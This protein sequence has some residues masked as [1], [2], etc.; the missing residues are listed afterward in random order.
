MSFDFEGN[1]M[2]AE[3]VF[4]DVVELSSGHAR[5]ELIRRLCPDDACV[6]EVQSLLQAHEQAGGFLMDPFVRLSPLGALNNPDA[7]CDR[8]PDRSGTKLGRYDIV[9]RLGAGGMGEVYL[10]RDTQ[11]QR[12]VGLKILSHVHTKNS[13]WL[14]RFIREAKVA[15]SVNHPNILTVH[16]IGQSAELQFIVTEYVEGITLRDRL[17]GEPLSLAEILEIAIQTAGALDAAHS[18]GIVHRDLKPENIMIRRDGLV[19][20]LD[21]GLARQLDPP[22]YPPNSRKPADDGNARHHDSISLPGSIMGTIHYMSPEQVRGLPVDTRSDLFSAGVVIYEMLTGCQPFRGATASDV[23]VSILEREPSPFVS[24]ESAVPA[25]LRRI[26]SRLLQKD[27]EQRFQTAGDFCAELRK[28]TKHSNPVSDSGCRT[29][30]TVPRTKSAFEWADASANSGGGRD[31]REDREIPE[32]RYTCSGSVNIAY[33]VFGDGDLDLVFVMGWVSHL[34]WFWKEPLFARFLR[35]L[36]TFARVI[37]FDKR[38]TGLSDRVEVDQLPTLEQRMD[39][40]RAVMDAVDSQRAVLC[41]V[42]EGGPM[43]VLFAATYP[44]KT[45]AVTMIGSYAR[46]LWAE[47]YPWGVREEDRSH[48]LEEIRRHWGGPVG[49]EDR[50][51]SLAFDPGFREWWATYL[52]MGASPGAALA[53][54]QMNAQIDIRQ[55]LPMIQVPTLVIHRTN[56][57]CLKI[58]EGRHL[59]EHIPGARF[60]ELPGADHLPFVG[61][62]DAVLAAM[63][64]FLAAME[65]T[66]GSRRVLA[67]VLAVKPLQFL[68]GNSS[69]PNRPEQIRVYRSHAIREVELF[70][71]AN[72]SFDGDNFV[73]VFDGPTRAIRAAM[74]INDSAARLGLKL[75]AGLHIGECDVRGNSVRGPAVD[76]ADAISEIAL[77]HEIVVSSTI[78]DLVAGSGIQFGEHP[79]GEFRTHSGVSKLYSVV[80]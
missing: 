4:R 48:F 34:E 64:D 69:L 53:L 49:I 70:R 60:V 24:P 21:F 31:E 9:R 63:E 16:E 8:A 51:P 36:G 2:N 54:T 15:S 32:V 65:H 52:R 58:E 23:L 33:Q 28:V 19:K 43:C 18:A 55:I 29:P 7:R 50:A 5:Q 66:P 20:V 56:D 37:L 75:R 11:L 26:I 30:D 47:D 41:G 3:E 17:G 38:G 62:Q 57:R 80:R 22:D 76:F 35:R 40:V 12:D 42:S 45:I 27:R 10:A 44:Q 78:K 13:A 72:A 46:R 61:D 67:T 71:G 59:A 1:R 68:S 73:A 77:A 6:R 39:D 14:R 25:E 74:A 79:S